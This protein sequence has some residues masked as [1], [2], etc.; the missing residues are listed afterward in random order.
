MAWGSTSRLALAAGISTLLTAI[1]E[2]IIEIQ[3]QYQQFE[4]GLM[5]M[6]SL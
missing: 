4:G 5:K 1:I 2:R 3:L 6:Q